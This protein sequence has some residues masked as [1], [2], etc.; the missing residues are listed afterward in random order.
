MLL[1]CRDSIVKKIIKSTK[2]KIKTLQQDNYR[3]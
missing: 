2:V 1:A 3:S